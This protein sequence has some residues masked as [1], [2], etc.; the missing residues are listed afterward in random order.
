MTTLSIE[1]EQNLAQDL[2]T[3]AERLGISLAEVINRFLQ[4]GL[5][6]ELDLHEELTPTPQLMEW[7]K[8]A[9]EAHEKGELVAMSWDEALAEL[10]R[11]IEESP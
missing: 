5:Q 6:N 3:A 1:L 11:M 8:E 2:R 10:D 9:H 4:Q 7:I